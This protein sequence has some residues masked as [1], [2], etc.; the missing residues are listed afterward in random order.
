VDRRAFSFSPNITRVLIRTDLVT[1]IQSDD[2]A[3]RLR[4]A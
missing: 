2:P 3:Y 1:G 4:R